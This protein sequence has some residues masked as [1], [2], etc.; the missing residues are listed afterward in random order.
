MIPV[1][2]KTAKVYD[3]NITYEKHFCKR[4]VSIFAKENMKMRKEGAYSGIS[5][6][7]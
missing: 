7:Y 2:K 6:W 5:A 4:Y 1:D 3:I